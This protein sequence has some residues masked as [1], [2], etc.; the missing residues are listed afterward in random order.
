M[1]CHR[2]HSVKDV[3]SGRVVHSRNTGRKPY[4]SKQPEEEKELTDHLVLAAKSRVWENS[5]R[6]YEPGGDLR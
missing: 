6:C 2:R 3:L 5:T 4:L 1:E